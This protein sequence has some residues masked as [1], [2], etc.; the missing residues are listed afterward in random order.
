[1]SPKQLEI[2]VRKQR[3][4]KK[5]EEKRIQRREERE[6]QEAMEARLKASEEKRIARKSLIS[7]MGFDTVPGT[8]PEIT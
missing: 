6:E 8:I 1:M 4:E 5:N 7:Q 2:E 3:Q